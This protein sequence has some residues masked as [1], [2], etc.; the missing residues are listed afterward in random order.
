MIQERRRENIGGAQRR[1]GEGLFESRIFQSIAIS[2]REK[3]GSHLEIR[4]PTEALTNTWITIKFRGRGGEAKRNVQTRPI[5][6]DLH[7][8]GRIPV[9]SQPTLGLSFFSIH[10]PI[11]PHN[12]RH[13][14]LPLSQIDVIRRWMDQPSKRFFFFF[15]WR[16]GDFFFFIILYALSRIFDKSRKLLCLIY[17]I[18][19]FEIFNVILFILFFCAL[20]ERYRL[21]FLIDRFDRQLKLNWQLLFYLFL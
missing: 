13:L 17:N 5:C 1:E 10:V 6:A 4:P 15:F 2:R 21:E 8:T 11:S 19:I 9:D 12:P 20:C 3:L 16:K 14:H 18:C 7:R